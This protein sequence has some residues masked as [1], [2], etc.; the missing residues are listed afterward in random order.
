MSTALIVLAACLG[1]QDPSGLSADER[2]SVEALIRRLGSGRVEE[3]AEA[4]QRLEN[5][6]E[7]AVPFLKA[8]RK[9][10][11]GEE[12]RSSLAVVISRLTAFRLDDLMER[13]RIA[14][15]SDDWTK[16]GWTDGRLERALDTLL[17]KLGTAVGGF[18]VELPVDFENAVANQDQGPFALR[19]GGALR[20]MRSGEIGYVSKAILLVDGSVRIGFADNCIILATGAV[21]VAHGSRNFILAGCYIEVSHDGSQLRRPEVVR[22][23]GSVLLSGSAL[24]V[25]HAYGAVCGAPDIVWISHAT[26]ATFVNTP[27]RDVGHE[28]GTLLRKAEGLVLTWKG[29]PGKAAL[30]DRLRITL[31]VDSDRGGRL[32]LFRTKE[33]GGEYVVREGNELRD[34]S[35]K[36]LAGLEGWK[37][38]FVTREYAL[39]EG[40]EGLAA[41]RKTDEGYEPVPR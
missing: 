4:R 12:V 22:G 24:H 31:L 17:Q 3:R 34:P 6:G 29:A 15:S 10:A 41:F 14:A 23:K 2:E 36:V 25:A 19:K 27:R 18:D 28:D 40:K 26:K 30:K 35:G 16:K 11:R 37:L 1:S 8:A 39:F 13:V 21:E 32:A 7:R 9:C 38:V 20:V 5:L 33:G